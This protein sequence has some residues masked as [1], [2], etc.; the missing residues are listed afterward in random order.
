MMDSASG[1]TEM[2]GHAGGEEDSQRD[3]V[4][5]QAA[6]PCSQNQGAG[7]GGRQRE[8]RLAGE[9]KTFA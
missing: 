9:A 7:S 2:S 1:S 5:R 6:H 8:E 4:R 3:R